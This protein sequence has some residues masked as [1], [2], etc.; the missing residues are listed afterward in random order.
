MDPKNLQS[1][2]P[3]LREAYERVMGTSNVSVQADPP[4]ADPLGDPKPAANP[5]ADPPPANLPIPAPKMDPSPI[6][7]STPLPQQPSPI[8]P[9]PSLTPEPNQAMQAKPAPPSEFA[10]DVP[11]PPPPPPSLMQDDPPPANTAPADPPTVSFP[12]SGAPAQQDSSTMVQ[13][14]KSPNKIMPILIAG[15]LIVFFIVWAFLW[16]TILGLKF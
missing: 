5:P 1:L 8:E 9:P 13:A 10:A 16:I 4:P 11:P 2:D 14:A 12:A 7:P 6:M 3:K 15:A